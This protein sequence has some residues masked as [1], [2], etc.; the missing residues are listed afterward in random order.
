MLN[1]PI[2]TTKPARKE[3]QHGHHTAVAGSVWKDVQGEFWKLLDYG[4][5]LDDAATIDHV[6]VDQCLLPQIIVR[7][8]ARLIGAWMNKRPTNK[9]PYNYFCDYLKH[10]NALVDALVN[11]SEFCEK[12]AD[13]FRGASSRDDLDFS[14]FELTAYEGNV[15]AYRV[16]DL[17]EWAVKNG[18]VATVRGI[19]ALCMEYYDWDPANDDGKLEY[20]RIQIEYFASLEKQLRRHI[21]GQDAA[22]GAFVDGLFEGE[23]LTSTKAGPG[24]RSFLFALPA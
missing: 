23:L 14:A 19:A 5:K 18:C 8:A 21:V 2:G 9:T 3:Q 20:D 1:Q 24:Q 4:F 6:D 10:T 15:F 11:N 17:L 13:H 7:G 22:I 16:R 12:V